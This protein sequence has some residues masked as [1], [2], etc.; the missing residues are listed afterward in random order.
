MTKHNKQDI[1]H[2][3]YAM[4]L[5][6]E[7]EAKLDA[8]MALLQD[9]WYTRDNR[10]FAKQIIREM[11]GLPSL[12]EK[13]L[14]DQVKEYVAV[15]DGWFSVTDLY[16]ELQAVTTQD[17]NTIRV[18]IKRLYDA[19]FI[20]KHGQKN[21]VYRKPYYDCEEIDWINADDKPVTI[22]LPLDLHRHVALYHG[23]VV[24]IAG[25]WNAGKSAFM[26][27]TARLNMD[28]WEID[29]LTSEMK[30]QRFK[31]R[32]KFMRDLLGTDWEKFN[33]KVRVRGREG[34]FQDVLEPDKLTLIDYLQLNDNFYQV[35]E[36]FRTIAEKLEK[37]IAMVA[38]Q[39]DK[40]SEYGYGREKGLQRPMLYLTIDDGY[41]K[42]IKAKDWVTSENPNGKIQEFKLYKGVNFQAVGTLH[43]AEDDPH[44]KKGRYS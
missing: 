32:M 4:Y 28:I 23:D 20:E 41:V 11:A 38:I 2:D 30:G 1:D 39:K 5:D 26:M 8:G 3:L 25:K 34:M 17:K 37:G 18:T 14:G 16:R 24:A 44:Y 19:R 43:H 27:E 9:L 36:H 33:E 31:K 15:T 13:R 21:G 12:Q 7:D 10:T 22:Y 42:I 40:G 6:N 29:F 35:G